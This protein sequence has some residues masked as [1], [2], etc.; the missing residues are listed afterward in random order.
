MPQLLL[1]N[2]GRIVKKSRK[3]RTPAQRAATRRMIAANK[4]R[5]SPAKRRKARRSNPLPAVSRVARRAGRVARRTYS[6]IRRRR[7]PISLGGTSSYLSAFKDAAVQG[8][9]AVAVDVAY[10]YIEPMMPAALQRKP[11]SLG[12][13]DAVKAIAT[14]AL[15]RLLSRPTRGLSQRAAKGALTVQVHGIVSGLLP[16]GMANGVGRVGWMTAAPTIN[17]SARVG[18]NRLGNVGAYT[19]PGQTALLNGSRGGVGAYMPP[20]RTALLS[21]NAAAR[22]GA[23]VR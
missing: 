17:A 22:E 14:V 4:R 20:G 16:A 6:R 8:A 1:I 9:G 10:G 18:P 7:N 5:A 13:G 23:R 21:G 19:A 2:P 11:G 15:G 3:S 12:L